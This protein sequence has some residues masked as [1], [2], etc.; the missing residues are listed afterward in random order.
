[1]RKITAA[2]AVK[3]SLMMTSQNREYF[4]LMDR[5]KEKIKAPLRHVKSFTEPDGQNYESQL[6]DGYR[7]HGNTAAN[8]SASITHNALEMNQWHEMEATVHS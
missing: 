3:K 2:N 5:M 7:L 4:S 6:P 1:M 8:L